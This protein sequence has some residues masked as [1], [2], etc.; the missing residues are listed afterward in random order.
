MPRGASSSLEELTKWLIEHSSLAPGGQIFV[1]SLSLQWQ[2]LD[3]QCKH[4]SVCN[5]GHVTNDTN[6]VAWP[7]MAQWQLCDQ[8]PCF[9]LLLLHNDKPAFL[10]GF[11]N[12]VSYFSFAILFAYVALSL[13]FIA[14]WKSSC[15]KQIIHPSIL[16]KGTS[17][18]VSRT[19]WQRL[20]IFSSCR[21]VRHFV[22][23][24]FAACL[25]CTWRNR[26]PQR[27]ADVRWTF[28]DTTS[29]STCSRS[30]RCW[31]KGWGQIRKSL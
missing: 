15:I 6:T 29:R 4:C 19:N 18:R 17:W 10:T 20:L 5:E 8:C 31:G 11:N 27:A 30:R 7:M 14:V 2:L 1:I 26:A 12:A 21:L 24:R 16:S 22:P 28:P 13:H 23:G 25:D 9:V 3:K